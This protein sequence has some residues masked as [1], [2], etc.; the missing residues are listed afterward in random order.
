MRKV[1]FWL[2]VAMVFVIPW[3]NVVEIDSLGTMGRI[4]GLLAAGFWIATVVKTGQ[5]RKPHPFHIVA[6]IFVLW[7][8]LSIFWSVDVDATAE[9]MLTY[10]QLFVLTYILW[11]L[12]RTPGAIKIGMQVYVLGGFISMGSLWANYQAGITES[13]QRYTATGFNGNDLSWILGLGLPIAWHLAISE[14][15]NYRFSALLRIINFA[16]IP[17][18]FFSITLTASRTGFLA[19]GPLLLFVIISF[20]RLKFYAQVLLIAAAIVST[21][22]V[23]PFVPTSSIQRFAGTGSEVTEGDLNNRTDVWREGIAIFSENP[24]FGIGSGAFR[25]AAIETNKVAHNF[26][27]SVSAELGLVGIGLYMT[28]VA[29]A[30]YYTFFLP[31]WTSRLWLVVFMIWLLGAATHSYEHRKTDLVN[32]GYGHHQR[33]Y[34]CSLY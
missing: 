15:N 5:F 13:Y 16:Y 17:A 20:G 33:L 24:V 10:F 34:I 19:F 18:T 3:E 26:A 14:D 2:S 12:Y 23:L 1:A 7:N 9:R 32:I 8:G 6:L 28:L 4:T 29:M 22:V 31:K 25:T 11:D 27:L 21:I 30:V